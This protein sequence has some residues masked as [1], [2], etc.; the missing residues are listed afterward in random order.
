M[1]YM[2]SSTI[3]SDPGFLGQHRRRIWGRQA[4]TLTELIIG[5]AISSII[6]AGVLTTFLMLGRSGSSAANYSI[7]EAEVR[8]GIEEFSQDLRMASAITWN[9][10]TSLTLTVPN[11]YSGNGGQVTYAYDASTSGPTAQS[12]Y[13]MPGDTTS[14]AAKTIFVRR[15]SSF[16]FERYNRLHATAT[17]DAETKRIQV[18]LNVRRTGS[19][20]V[21]ANTILVSASY[22]LRNKAVH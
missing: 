22:I 21:A 15:I 8:R 13:R 12:F 14:G 2:T 18:T 3:R 17:N 9:S 11:N 19:T 4:F 1:V 10:A 16:Q 6:L 20:L 5:S 7:S